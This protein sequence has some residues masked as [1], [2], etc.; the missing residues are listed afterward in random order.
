MVVVVFFCCCCGHPKWFFLV[1]FTEVVDG[2]DVFA[3][4][5]EGEDV[6][7]SRRRR[8]KEK[9][10]KKKRVRIIETMA[11]P[12]LKGRLCVW[13]GEGH[14][15]RNDVADWSSATANQEAPCPRTL[16][17]AEGDAWGGGGGGQRIETFR[18]AILRRLHSLD[19]YW[20]AAPGDPEP[21]PPALAHDWVACHTRNYGN[22]KQQRS[23]SNN[24]NK[25]FAAAFTW[26]TFREI[27]H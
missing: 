23:F 16:D 27:F 5:G 24:E 25:V 18:M 20:S 12:S 9:K 2:S 4:R 11:I 26:T 3:M 14:T 17:V 13:G 6:D 22:K 10:N 21:R 1:K 15:N 7:G 8:W 19:S